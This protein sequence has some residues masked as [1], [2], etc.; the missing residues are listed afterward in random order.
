LNQEI[1]QKE[2]KAK[3]GKLTEEKRIPDFFL[4]FERVFKKKRGEIFFPFVSHEK[5]SFL[6]SRSQKL[7]KIKDFFSRLFNPMKIHSF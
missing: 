5:I 2:E 1:F 3:F 7:D 4:V 6:F